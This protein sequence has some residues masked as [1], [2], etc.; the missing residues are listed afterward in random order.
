[1]ASRDCRSRARLTPGDRLQAIPFERELG[2]DRVRTTCAEVHLCLRAGE[3]SGPVACGR[4]GRGSA[5]AVSYDVPAGAARR[6]AACVRRRSAPTRGPSS[7]AGSTRPSGSGRSAPPGSSRASRIRVHRRAWSPK[8]VSWP[9]TTRS[10]SRWS[11]RIPSPTRSSRRWR[12]GTMRRH[13]TGPSSRSTRVT[14]AAAASRSASTRA[15]SR[16]TAS[17]WATCSTTCRG[18]PSGRRRRGPARV[19]GRRSSAS[20]SRSWRSR[21][22]PPRSRSSGA[23]TSIATAR[24]TAS[25]PTGRRATAA[26]PASC[27]TSTT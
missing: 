27:R 25:R 2:R 16:W 11:T 13:R 6:A 9:M 19:A 21:C 23:S 14:I 22:R 15:A 7:M 10:T 26:L 12:A 5:T 20:R 17:G 8:P 4:L 1:M 24:I 18:T 3:R